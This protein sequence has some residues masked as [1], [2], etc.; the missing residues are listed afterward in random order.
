MFR[1][2]A[3][4]ESQPG[5][6]APGGG[7]RRGKVA[8]AVALGATAC[9]GIA[10]AAVSAAAPGTASTARSG[11]GSARPPARAQPARS[12]RTSP[13]VFW[14]GTDSTGIALHGH[15]PAKLPIGGTD[16][17]YIGM[18]GNWATWQH[19]GTQTIWSHEDS[20]A[21]NTSLTRYHQGIGTGV[22]WFM[23]GPGVDPH[24]DGTTREARQWGAAQAAR[25]LR[26]IA[27][28]KSQVP[29]PVVFMDVELPGHA[30]TF[31]PADD[32]GWNS[33]YTAPCSGR[34]RLGH[35]A[36]QV[37][38]AEL[39]GFAAY[40]TSHS[41][42]KAGVYS[43]PAIWPQIFGHGAAAQI[44]RTYEW[45]YDAAT[46]SLARKPAGWCL[47]GTRTCAH[48]FGGVTARSRYALMWQWSGGGGT[49]NGIGDF[50]QIDGSRTP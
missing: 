2:R 20:A 44:P 37:D 48:F 8:A 36:P 33:V 13:A 30:P 7:R 19:C 35:I 14:S 24:Y 21:A 50:D 40:L 22:Y 5:H 9:A 25:T 1:S 46:A 15:A 12:P 3:A 29:Y 32:N 26:Q 39:N 23:G 41:R 45:T 10:L 27:H 11:P 42:Y 17:G 43:S 34:A 47:A 6:R 31:T 28:K 38:R 49:W 4:S 16:G 18:A